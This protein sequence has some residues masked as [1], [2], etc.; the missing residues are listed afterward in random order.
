M[1]FDNIF[2]KF[3]WG[4]YS[5]LFFKIRTAFFSVSTF[6]RPL[7]FFD[8]ISRILSREDLQKISISFPIGTGIIK[9]FYFTWKIWFIHKNI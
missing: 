7:L 9:F 1:K 6:S 2:L 5:E 4:W 8:N 3:I